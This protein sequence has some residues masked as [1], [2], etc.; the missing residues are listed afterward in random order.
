MYREDYEKL[1]EI[2]KKENHSKYKVINYNNSDWYFHNFSIIVDTT[3][4]I[5]DNYKK[6]KQDTHLFLDVFPVDKF[7][8]VSFIKKITI[9]SSIR[10]ISQTKLKYIYSDN[11]IKNIF[12]K[13]CW[14]LLY[15]SNPRFFN[16]KIEKLIKKNTDCNGKYEAFLG[17]GDVK[18]ILPAG[19]CD[20]YIELEFEKNLLKAPKNY[21]TILNNY[22]GDY[23]KIPPKE[24]CVPPHNFEAYKL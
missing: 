7:N 19:T 10:S 14:F 18:E 8:D 5:P 3:T 4:T 13:I 9:I 16:K 23:L 22:Y 21:D 15:F 1:I 6:N 24:E 11:K 17:M 12:K 20:D 2:I